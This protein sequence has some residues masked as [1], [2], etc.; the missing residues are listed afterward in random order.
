VIRT[1]FSA[2]QFSFRG[3]QSDAGVSQT[4]WSVTQGYSRTIW[5]HYQA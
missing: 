2:S 1:R 3:T 5:V 4:L